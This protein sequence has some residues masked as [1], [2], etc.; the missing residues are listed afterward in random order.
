MIQ[1]KIMT[2]HSL[3]EAMDSADIVIHCTPVGMH[4][5][6]GVSIV[7]AAMFRKGQ[8]VF[9]VVYTPIE[10]KLMADAR[11][12]GLQVIPGVE[13]FIN[14]AVLQFERFTRRGCAGGCDAKSCY[15]SFK[16]M[17]IVLIGCRG[18][19]KSEVGAILAGRL[20][21]ACVGMD[22]EIVCRA[23]MSIPD[24]VEKFVLESIPGDGNRSGPGF[25]C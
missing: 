12:G 13:M 10:T 4:P 5:R 11:S 22:A 19:G 9:D 25:I 17:N 24:I 21:M 23:G 7:P 2:D 14:Q 1:S 16:I 6:E 3:A 15:G 8:V 18:T 20:K